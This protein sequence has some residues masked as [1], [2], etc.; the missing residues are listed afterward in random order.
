[1]DGQHPGLL[2]GLRFKLIHIDLVIPV[3]LQRV[4]DRYRAEK[5][6]Y[7]NVIKPYRIGNQDFFTRVDKCGDRSICA[8]ADADGYQDLFGSVGDIVLFCELLGDRGPKLRSAI[9]GGIENM[10][11]FQ[12]VISGFFDHFRRIKIRTADFHMNNILTFF[13][14]SGG[15]FHHHADAGEG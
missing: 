12:T 10:P 2:R 4:G 9:I 15:P 13:L 14:H 7:V 1:M 8:F 11:F 3:F 5:F 6:G